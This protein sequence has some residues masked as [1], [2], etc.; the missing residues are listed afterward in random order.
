MRATVHPK[1]NEK[2][3]S[4]YQQSCNLSRQQQFLFITGIAANWCSG[5]AVTVTKTSATASFIIHQLLLILPFHMLGLHTSVLFQI[6]S[7]DLQ[8]HRR[9][10]GASH[11]FILLMIRAIQSFRFYL[12][13]IF[14]FTFPFAIFSRCWDASAFPAHSQVCTSEKGAYTETLLRKWH[15]RICTMHTAPLML[16][17]RRKATKKRR[18]MI[19]KGSVIA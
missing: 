10:V 16:V 6:F 9:T 1:T 11:I 7:C 5:W 13:M 15:L 18:K 3:G 2:E 12:L 4:I 14:F 8:L 19:A 17:R